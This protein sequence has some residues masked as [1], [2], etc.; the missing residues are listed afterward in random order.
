MSTSYV[1]EG[2]LKILTSAKNWYSS[3]EIRQLIFMSSRALR[4]KN[5]VADYLQS[6]NNVE[7]MVY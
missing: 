7:I 4:H 2:R 1:D 5:A 3:N 6:C